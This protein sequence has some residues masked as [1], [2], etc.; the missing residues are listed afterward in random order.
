[1]KDPSPLPSIFWPRHPTLAADDLDIGMILSSKN[2][3]IN[4]WNGWVT[5]VWLEAIGERLAPDG[6]EPN[7]KVDMQAAWVVRMVDYAHFWYDL[8][9]S[10]FLSL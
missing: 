5:W 10:L 1:M 2:N 6:P 4:Q 7:G 3:R 8:S 9:L